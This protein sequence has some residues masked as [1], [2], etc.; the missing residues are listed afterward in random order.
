MKCPFCRSKGVKR[1]PT[2]DWC[3]E[4]GWAKPGMYCPGCGRKD[5]NRKHKTPGGKW[6]NITVD[7][8]GD[9]Y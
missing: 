8:R 7:T 1:S 6:H 3:E 2:G 4:C 9:P 5:V